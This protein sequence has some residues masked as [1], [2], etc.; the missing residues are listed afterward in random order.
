MADDHKE[1]M[2]R[3]WGRYGGG[4]FRIIHRV[5]DLGFPWSLTPPDHPPFSSSYATPLTVPKLLCSF[6]EQLLTSK[7]MAIL[8]LYTHVVT[9]LGHP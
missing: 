1:E 8:N 6:P 2:G 7:S 5:T 3:G 4:T 9:K